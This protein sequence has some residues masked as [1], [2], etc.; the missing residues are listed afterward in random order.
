MKVE[1]Q[2]KTYPYIVYVWTETIGGEDDGNV[3]V[4]TISC[5]CMTWILDFVIDLDIT[6]LLSTAT[7]LFLTWNT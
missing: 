1:Q 6:I 7:T 5:D 4:N 2:E 3:S